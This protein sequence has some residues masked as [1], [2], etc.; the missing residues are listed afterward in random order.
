LVGEERG[1]NGY[2]RWGCGPYSED[3]S[4]ARWR[5]IWDCR[6]ARL[7]AV[8][9]A[10]PALASRLRLSTG[11]AVG[12]RPRTSTAG[13]SPSAAA[14][15]RPRRDWFAAES[16]SG[17]R[18][19]SAR[20][21]LWADSADLAPGSEPPKATFSWSCM[22]MAEAIGVVAIGTCAMRAMCGGRG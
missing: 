2:V 15:A 3:T 5:R 11:A 1:P 12:P 6:R 10:V 20:R 17:V 14:E 13:F 9:T 4:L 21:G 16:S 19:E 7:A 8:S 22:A 18:A